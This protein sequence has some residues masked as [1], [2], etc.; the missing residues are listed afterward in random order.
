MA[1][2]CCIVGIQG[3]PVSVV[4]DHNVEGRL[5]PMNQ[6]D[7]LARDVLQLLAHHDN[8]VRFGKAARQRALLYDQRLTLAALTSLIESHGSVES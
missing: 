2:G 4:I 7:L 3:M 6:P 8:R 1:C 5:I